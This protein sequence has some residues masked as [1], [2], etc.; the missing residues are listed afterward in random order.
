V[1]LLHRL[2]PFAAGSAAGPAV[3]FW[4]DP[5]PVAGDLDSAVLRGRA[6]CKCSNQ[7]QLQGMPQYRSIWCTSATL[8]YTTAIWQAPMLLL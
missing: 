3:A 5:E 7:R 8:D 1:S 6:R 2:D 4:Q